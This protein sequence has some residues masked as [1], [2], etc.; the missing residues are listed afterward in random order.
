MT[1]SVILGS[2]SALPQKVV[3]NAELSQ[4]IETS[5]TWIIERTGIRQRHIASADETTSSL[6]IEA[7]RAVKGC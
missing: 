3:T 4:Q 7:S 2:G 1:R 6:A 5:D